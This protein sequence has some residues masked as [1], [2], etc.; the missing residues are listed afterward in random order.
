MPVSV[1]L[2][3]AGVAIGV[4]GRGYQAELLERHPIRHRDSHVD[5]AYSDRVAGR[6]RS[7]STDKIEM[8]EPPVGRWQPAPFL[9]ICSPLLSVI[10]SFLPINPTAR[11]KESSRISV[12][13]LRTTFLQPWVSLENPHHFPGWLMFVVSCYQHRRACIGQ[14]SIIRGIQNHPFDRHH[15]Q[16]RRSIIQQVKASLQYQRGSLSAVAYL[17][18]SQD[19]CDVRLHC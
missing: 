16:M 13:I 7:S 11:T 15:P 10:S 5:R 6:L 19:A 2:D 3:M 4:G 18:L 17:E 9:P 12:S 14:S 8:T 1:V